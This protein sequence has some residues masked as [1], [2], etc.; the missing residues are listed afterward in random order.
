[1]RRLLLAVL[2]LVAVMAPNAVHAEEFDPSAECEAGHHVHGFC[3]GDGDDGQE[4]VIEA[5]RRCLEDGSC[6][7][8]L[9]PNAPRLPIGY[10]DDG[11]PI[12]P[13]APDTAEPDA[14]PRSSGPAGPTPRFTG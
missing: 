14:P 13:P 7:Q 12:Y 10:A 2:L 8:P 6:G 9:D 4:D 11:S 3:G 5:V 1:M